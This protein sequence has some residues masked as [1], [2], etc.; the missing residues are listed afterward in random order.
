[1]QTEIKF[2]FVVRQTM[3][4]TFSSLLKSNNSYRTTHVL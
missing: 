4:L 3:F 1:M 2:N